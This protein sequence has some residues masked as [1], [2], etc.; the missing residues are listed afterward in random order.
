[1]HPYFIRESVIKAI[2]SFFFDQGFH[3]VITPVLN[4]ALPVEPN[5]YP[6]KTTW[7]TRAG[8]RELFMSASPEIGLKKM[9][10]KG[11]GNCFAIGKSFRNLEGA[12]SLHN[13]EFLML[14]WYREDATYDQI[15]TDTRNLL[16]YIHSSVIARSE[17]DDAISLR[18]ASSSPHVILENS[19]LTY[20]SHT[21]SLTDPWPTFSLVELFNQHLKVDLENILDDIAMT[22][23]CSK[24][25]YN[26]KNATW[27]E[28][29]DQI[30]V[31]EIE[32][33]L[34]KTPFFLTDFPARISPLCT[35]NIQ[36]PYLA[37]R[38]E[39]Y[40]FRMEVANGNNE[41]TDWK[42]VQSVFE[43]EKK[44]REQ[45]GL[46][47]SPVD[48]EFI[49]AL[50]VMSQ[51]KYAGIGLGLDRLAMIFADVADINE[52]ELLHV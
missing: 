17:Y 38:F 47:V 18:K 52:I 49:E 30:L 42:T 45:H 5:L 19:S 14:E 32:P 22:Q 40:M 13:P 2:R 1:M 11:I 7:S 41:N 51:K 20:Q 21:I 48:Y 4:N 27:G 36:K 16:L 10:A 12:G 15:M 25:G 43:N 3:E 9:L 44:H 50:K 46:A 24:R 28:L 23:W 31:N 6:F 33:K 37:E 29:F 34:P 39:F 35:V 8:E 26:T